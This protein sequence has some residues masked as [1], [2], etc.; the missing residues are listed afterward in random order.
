MA[1]QTVKGTYD[2]L[3]ETLLKF[4]DLEDL[5]RHFLELYGYKEI[6]TPVFEYTGVFQKEN[7]TSDMVTKEM[8]T[9]SLNG[10]D[11]LT[12]RPEGTA[13][14]VRSF[15]ENKM[16]GTAEMPV[17]LAYIEEMFRHERPQKGRQ[18]QFT[19]MG[20]EAMGDKDPLIDAEVIAL[21]YFYIRAIGLSGVKVLV[22]SLGDNES[23]MKY[24]EELIS[25]FEPHQDQLCADCRNRLY[26]NPLRILDCKVDHDSELIANAPKMA[27]NEQSQV[28]FDKVKHYLDIMGIPYEIDD[29][30][31]R[32]LDY[33]T[34]TVF[35]VVS[36]N[37]A[38]GSQ[39]TIFG[40]GRYDNLIK[41]MGGPEMSGIGFAIGVERLLILAEAEGVFEEY[42]P[43]IDCYVINLNED[44]DYML[45]I[46]N[47]LRNNGLTT[48][49]NYY[50]RSL[51]AQ[52]RS[53]E[54]KNA[55]FV[56]IIGEDEVKDN[57]VTLKD[58]L[59]KAQETVKK[60]E[61]SARIQQLMEDYYE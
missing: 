14:V 54:R 2:L 39:A 31:V 44:P 51:K 38:S 28:Y 47:D 43:S 32:G 4:Q 11:S 45:Q 13:G 16:Y 34:D 48:E 59:T 36:T 30:L 33:Y 22:N 49:M 61:V 18:R 1:Y 37:E 50:S 19:Q 15:V 5:F 55:R 58:T 52:F 27:L 12:L 53:S 17:K 9:F 57:T 7:D 42:K 29:K 56:L 25:Y 23:R 10:K 40:G 26:K 60:E 8:Y 41:E 46:V 6:K 3:P 24:R 35:E 21:G 20:I